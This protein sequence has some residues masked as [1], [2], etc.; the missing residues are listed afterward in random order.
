MCDASSKNDEGQAE[1]VIW[2]IIILW[3]YR[4]LHLQCFL[5]FLKTTT[6]KDRGEKGRVCD[7]EI[8]SNAVQNDGLGA[9][10]K[11]IDECYG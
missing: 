10:L 8:G 6:R 9:Q 5:N 11:I 4:Q 7:A 3:K 2:H 1:I